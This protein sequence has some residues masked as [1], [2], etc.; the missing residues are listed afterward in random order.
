MKINLKD[1]NNYENEFGEET[2]NFVRIKRSRPEKDEESR[3]KGRK[4][5]HRTK[6]KKDIDY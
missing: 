4:L 2:E 3:T 5:N 6:K 1:L